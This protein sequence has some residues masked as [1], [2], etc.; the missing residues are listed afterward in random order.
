MIFSRFL[1]SSLLGFAGVLLVRAKTPQLAG[2][3][4]S[5]EAVALYQYLHD[6]SGKQ[7]RGE[8]GPIPTVEILKPQPRGAW[9]V[10]WSDPGNVAAK[11]RAAV[12]E[13]Y[14]S[15]A[16]LAWEALPWVQVRNSTVHYPV[17]R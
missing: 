11:D 10:A 8:V 3:N 9:V 7:T 13:A 12:K 5:P 1:F 15:E 2:P 14:A 6:I 16:V 4:P 17:I